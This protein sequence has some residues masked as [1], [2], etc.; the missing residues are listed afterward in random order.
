MASKLPSPD[1]S[2][3]STYLTR[4]MY[5]GVLLLELAST[6]AMESRTLQSS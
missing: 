6:S 3:S 5:P 2:K 1:S 4:V